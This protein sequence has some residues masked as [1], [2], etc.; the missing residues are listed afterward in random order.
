MVRTCAV[1]L[2]AAGIAFAARAEEPPLK[3]LDDWLSG[4]VAQ[5]TL[6]PK[7]DV[8]GFVLTD[9]VQVHVAP[10]LAAALVYTARPGDPVAVQGSRNG[11]GRVVEAAEI[12]NR[13]SGVLFVNAG[14]E[15]GSNP[16]QS[17]TLQG[18]V[19]FV[20]HG[21]KGDANGAIL[22][23]GTVLHLPPHL[24]R[25]LAP[26]QPVTVQGRT[27]VTPM[28]KIVEVGKLTAGPGGS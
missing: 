4:T 14:P 24:A 25:D 23:D 10:H 11:P 22:E 15:H 8:D 13:S 2:A 18:K 26:G 17:E 21:P 5:Y 16:P 27:Q 9:G 12:R 28:A 20:L 7:G 3:P 6:T 1:A 19:R